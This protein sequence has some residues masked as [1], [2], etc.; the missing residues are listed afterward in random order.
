[1]PALTR[2]Q[3]Q[4]Y[5][6]LGA[7]RQDHGAPPTLQE[8]AA[9]LGIAGN[10]GVLRH[11]QALASKGL[12]VRRPGQA[13]GIVL[14]A[15]SSVAAVPLPVVG[16]VR[17]GMPQPAVEE[18]AGHFTVDA[19]LVRGADSFLLRV[20]GDSMIGAHIVAGDLAVV[21]PQ[22]TAENGEI[23]VA[24]IDGEA[25]LKRFYREADGRIRLQPENPAMAPLVI[26]PEQAELLIVGKV[27]GICRAL[28]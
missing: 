11:L 12:I 17:A 24:L 15:A 23:V 7:Y 13:R 16:T 20:Q 8:I 25:T 14:T 5:D 2:R 21:R 19:A 26:G 27:T 10:L 6:F 4:V 18:P 3:R 1:M 28:A 22:P 9:H